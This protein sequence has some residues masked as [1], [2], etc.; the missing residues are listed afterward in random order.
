MIAVSEA[1]DFNQD[2]KMSWLLASYFQNAELCINTYL[3]AQN[4]TLLFCIGFTAN[5]L[6]YGA[7]TTSTLIPTSL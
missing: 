6:P 2:G 3:H 7:R 5:L 4:A 1:I